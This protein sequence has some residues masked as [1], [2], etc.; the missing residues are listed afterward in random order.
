MSIELED[1][2]LLL[3]YYRTEDGDT[4][5]VSIQN[6]ND[7]T[8]F[9]DG[10][11]SIQVKVKKINLEKNYKNRDWL[12]KAYIDESRTMQDIADEYDVSPMTIYTWLK[13]FDIPTRSRG[14]R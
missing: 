9:V 6:E 7:T 4:R 12:V 1:D 13:R 2:E 14:R 3:I 10:D 11:Y 5:S 8:T